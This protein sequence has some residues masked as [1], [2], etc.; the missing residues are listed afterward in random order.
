MSPFILFLISIFHQ[1]DCQDRAS[2]TGYGG[3]VGSAHHLATEAGLKVLRN[4]GNAA[5]AAFAVQMTL[6]LV[7]PMMSGIGGGCF[8]LYYDY[9][10]KSVYALDGRE[11]AP[12]AYPG[13]IFCKNP[14]CLK[15]P[16]C[17]DC[18]YPNQTANYNEKRIGGLSV[19]TPG[20]LYAFY[21]LLKYFGSK[22]DGN[23]WSELLE[24]TKQISFDGFPMYDEMFNYL[25]ASSSCLRRFSD[26][27]ELFYDASTDQPIAINETFTNS[28]FGNL[29]QQFQDLGADASIE[30]FYNGTLAET[31]VNAT[32]NNPNVWQYESTTVQRPGLMTLSD[33]SGYKAVFRY[34]VAFPFMSCHA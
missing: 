15:N 1:S 24:Y 32:N 7:Q 6:N 14:N 28:N 12:N 30:W 5:D 26:S 10:N 31:I 9:E 16:D 23:E 25:N 27:Y 18:T 21:N 34:C 3:M 8:I 4:G 2:T 29:L 19:G 22:T 17:D 20:T 13:N 11:E 33:M